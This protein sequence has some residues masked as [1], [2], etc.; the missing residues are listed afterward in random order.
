[1]AIRVLYQN[2][3]I[4]ARSTNTYLIMPIVT[5]SIWLVLRAGRILPVNLLIKITG[6]ACG[7]NYLHDENIVHSDLKG[8]SVLEGRIA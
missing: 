4:T 1:M 7:L 6:I 8:V 2:G 3:K 5:K